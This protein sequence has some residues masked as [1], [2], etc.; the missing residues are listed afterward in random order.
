MDRDEVHE[1]LKDVQELLLPRQ[2][3]IEG[4]AFF[5]YYQPATQIRGEYYDYIRLADGRWVVVVAS[6]LGFAIR[7]TK[8]MAKLPGE[9]RSCLASESDPAEAVTRLNK[10]MCQFDLGRVATFV[11]VTLDPNTHEVTIVNAGHLSPIHRHLDGSVSLPSENETRLP[12]G[13]MEDVEYAAVK[14]TLQPGESLTLFTDGLF[15]AMN[16][17]GEQFTFDRM[18]EIVAASQGGPSGIGN[19]LLTQVRQHLG[20]RPQDDDMCLISFGPVPTVQVPYKVA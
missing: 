2:P 4:Y 17:A 11:M 19:S 8:F 6:G 1:L 7:L 15:K 10:R 14:V 9:V 16:A 13:V 3:V 20:D 18:C 5:D 12:I